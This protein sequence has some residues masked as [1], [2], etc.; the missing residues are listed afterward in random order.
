MLTIEQID[1]HP[2]MGYFLFREH[3]TKRPM[4]GSWRGETTFFNTY[5]AAREDAS[6]PREFRYS[7]IYEKFEIWAFYVGKDLN[8]ADFFPPFCAYVHQ[9]TK[10]KPANYR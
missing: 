5:E 7:L 1:K 2:D 10:P 9:P 4:R 3:G 6:Q 8:S